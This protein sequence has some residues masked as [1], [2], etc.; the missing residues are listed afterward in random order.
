M[1]YARFGS[2]LAREVVEI[3]DDIKSLDGGGFWAV[4]VTFE[5]AVTCVRFGRVTTTAPFRKQMSVSA[6]SGGTKPKA[7]IPS[8]IRIIPLTTRS[9]MCYWSLRPAKSASKTAS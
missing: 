5:G 8:E 4:V 6:V 2:R 7:I 3:S 9:H 1:A